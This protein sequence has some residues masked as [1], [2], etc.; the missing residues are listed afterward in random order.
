MKF[1]E[2]I[3]FCVLSFIFSSTLN[4]LKTIKID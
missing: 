3:R 2:D 1:K 4:L